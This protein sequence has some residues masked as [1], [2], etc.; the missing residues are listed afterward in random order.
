MKISK[1]ILLTFIIFA[2]LSGIA[3]GE[4]ETEK[5]RYENLFIVTFFALLATFVYFFYNFLSSITEKKVDLASSITLFMCIILLTLINN[6]YIIIY[7]LDSIL[8]TTLNNVV[9]LI[10][11][12]SGVLF[13][14]TIFLYIAFNVTKK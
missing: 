8:L 11:L 6:V 7:S 10:L 13:F 4:S 1:S 9:F 2:L 14:A 12:L 5:A 3:R